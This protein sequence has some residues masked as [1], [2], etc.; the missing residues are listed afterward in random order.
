MVN[1]IHYNSLVGSDINKGGEQNDYLICK[2]I[3]VF[4]GLNNSGKSR[5]LRSIFSNMQN[6]LDDNRTHF[7]KV[8]QRKNDICNLLSKFIE[9]YGGNDEIINKLH[10]FIKYFSQY[11]IDSNYF[12]GLTNEI[13]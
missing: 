6:I 5:L 3:N 8:Y 13:E 12:I 7:A 1:F 10:S 4:I 2:K 9:Y 11:E